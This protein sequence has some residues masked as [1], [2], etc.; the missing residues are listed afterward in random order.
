MFQRANLTLK[1]EVSNFLEMMENTSEVHKKNIDKFHS[2]IS[3]MENNH[4][5]CRE[6]FSVLEKIVAAISTKYVK[7][8]ASA[9]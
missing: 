2:K 5:L 1:E 6:D 7:S 8:L 9:R 3:E 4:N